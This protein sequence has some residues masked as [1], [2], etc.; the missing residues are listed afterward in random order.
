MTVEDDRNRARLEAEARRLDITPNALEM[1]RA[2]GTDLLRDILRDN[3]RNVHD[4]SGILPPETKREAPV[5]R[6]PTSQNGWVGPPK[7]ADWKPPGLAV[8]DRMLDAQDAR[9]RAERERQFNR[10]GGK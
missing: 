5:S 6:P 9:D 7:V 1:S 2:V 8:M 10:D 4:R 3:R